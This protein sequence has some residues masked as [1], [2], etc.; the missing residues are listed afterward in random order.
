[1]KKIFFQWT[2]IKKREK[3]KKKKKY[4]ALWLRWANAPQMNRSER[5]GWDGCRWKCCTHISTSLSLLCILSHI[6][7]VKDRPAHAARLGRFCTSFER[8]ESIVARD[9][10]FVCVCV[11]M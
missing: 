1:M 6:I 4:C 10:I 5:I 2:K 8:F 3:E 11:W 9:R 7:P